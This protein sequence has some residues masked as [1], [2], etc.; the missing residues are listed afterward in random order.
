MKVLMRYGLLTCLGWL[1]A[2]GIGFAQIPPVLLESSRVRTIHEIVGQRVESTVDQRI[3]AGKRFY[4]QGEWERAIAT[5]QPILSQS[6]LTPTQQATLWTYLGMAHQKQG[7][8]AAADHA[9]DTSLQLLVSVPEAE[10]ASIRAQVLNTQGQLALDQG[11]AEA[12]FTYWQQTTQIYRALDYPAGITG[13]LLNQASALEMSGHHRR[14]C[15]TILTAIGLE[16]QTCELTSTDAMVPV[17]E[18][19]ETQTD[20]SLQLL[21][22]TSL[23]NVLRQSGYLTQSQ[24]IL[25]QAVAKASSPSALPTVLLSLGQVEQARYRQSLYLYEQTGDAL[26]QMVSLAKQALDHYQAAADLTSPETPMAV[27]IAAPTLELLTQ[28]RAGSVDVLAQVKPQV[29]ARLQAQ[30]QL[31]KRLPLEQLPPSRSLITSQISLARSLTTLATGTGQPFTPGIQPA[32]DILPLLRRAYTQA[33]ELGD[34]DAQ[35]QALGAWGHLYEAGGNE[36][37]ENQRQARQFTQKALALAQSIGADHLA[38]RWQWQLGRLYRQDQ[39]QALTYYQA[40]VDSLENVRQDLVAVETDV[41]FLLRD[42]VEPLYRE[43]VTLLL[44]N[45]VPPQANLK[46]AVREIDALQ[47]ARLEDFLSCNLTQQVA[48]DETQLDPTAAI[49]YPIVL[50]EQL[51]VV[52]RLPQSDQVQFYRTPLSAEE[53]NRTLDSLRVQVEQPFLSDQFFELSQQVYDW[54]IRPIESLL[55]EQ[56]VDTLVFVSDG[57]L[58]NVPMAALHDGQQFLIERYGVA[59]SPSLQLPVSQP[60]GDVGLETLAFG[61]SKIRTDFLP[62]A[63]FN[64]LDNVEKELASIQSQVNAKSLINQHFTSD[65]LQTLVDEDPAS[66]IHL[67]THGQFSSNPGDTFLLSWDRRISLDDLSQMLN[68]RTGQRGIELL[69]LSACKTATGDSRATLGLAGV[70]IQSGARSTIASLWNVNDLATSELMSHL[71]RILAESGKTSRAQA[72]RQAQLQ[73]LQTPGYQAPVYWAAYVLVGN[74]R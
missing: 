18:A 41:R 29:T 67:A 12:A 14:A 3:E 74:W 57:A 32:T 62:H 65:N 10:G 22:M 30:L 55:V 48:L 9:L 1:M 44:E 5:W 68:R 51:A 27:Q 66:V 70:A 21:A 13:S 64:P 59:L 31:V 46:Q 53:I 19:V 61:L 58:R 28:L 38:Y 60:L 73:L 16:G 63:G 8:R 69:I 42:A 15:Q 72:L 40:A 34:V 37:E 36:V 43:L 24:Q 23:G 45:S 25:E 17:L 6:D 47:L 54:L 26:D 35:S 52:V 4:Q 7:D 49:V 20:P 50:P 11:R 56:S 2:M 33:T 71:Y 39:P